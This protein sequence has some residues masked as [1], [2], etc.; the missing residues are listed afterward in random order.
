MADYSRDHMVIG[1]VWGLAYSTK[2]DFDQFAEVE[3]VHILGLEKYHQKLPRSAD[4]WEDALPPYDEAFGSGNLPTLNYDT[5]NQ[6]LSL[7]GGI[8]KIDRPFMGTS[9]GIEN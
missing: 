9:P 1:E 8:Y 5:L 6:A 4:L 2:K 3:Y 7:V